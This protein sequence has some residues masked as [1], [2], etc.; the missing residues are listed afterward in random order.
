MLTPRERI[1]LK[2][3]VSEDNE[4]LV[5]IFNALSDANRCKLFRL[6]AKNPSINSTEASRTLNISISLVSQHFKVL[7]NNN[8]L[9]KHKRGREVFYSINAKDDTIK[10]ILSVIKE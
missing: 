1:K 6:I 2:K 3:I 5:E 4:R 10:A 7:V 8:L 9:F